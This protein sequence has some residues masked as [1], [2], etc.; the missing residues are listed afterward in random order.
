MHPGLSWDHI[1]DILEPSWDLLGPYWG[2]FGAVLG[3][4]WLQGGL[5]NA[6]LPKTCSKLF[7]KIVN[8]EAKIDR[9]L[10]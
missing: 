7:P 4:Q 8:S 3:M 10:S 9:N 1:G 6:K 2:N 5:R